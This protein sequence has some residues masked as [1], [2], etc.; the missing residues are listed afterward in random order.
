M[1]LAS[2]A[3]WPRPRFSPKARLLQHEY[4]H[5]ISSDHEGSSPRAR[6]RAGGASPSGALQDGARGA[7]R[8]S[9]SGR[10]HHQAR[11]RL[12]Y[13]CKISV[14]AGEARLCLL[15]RARRGSA[16]TSAPGRSDCYSTTQSHR[17]METVFAGGT[18]GCRHGWGCGL[19]SL[20]ISGLLQEPL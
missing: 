11:R 10:I 3:V 6:T 9:M 19:L 14:F 12:D 4:E 2:R 18:R 7:P 15:D 5:D 16:E 13:G 17:A 1:A 20:V 8:C